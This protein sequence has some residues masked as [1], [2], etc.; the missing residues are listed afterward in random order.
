MMIMLIIVG[1]LFGG[2]FLWKAFNA[3]MMKRYMSSMGSPPMTISTITVKSMPWQSHVKAVGTLRAIIGVNVTTQLAGQVEKIYFSPGA[4]VK[5]NDILVQLNA[6][7]E[8]ALLQ[9]LQ[10]QVQLAKITYERDK[11][12]YAFKAVSKQT[13]DIDEWNLKNKIALTAEQAATVAKKTLR[14][15][16]SGRLGISKVNPGQYL[17]VGDTVTTLQTLDPIFMDFYVPQQELSKL[18]LGQSVVVKA[19]AY[20]KQKYTGTI[21]TIEPAVDVN[22]RNVQVEATIN[23]SKLELLPG[24]FASVEVTTGAPKSYLTLPQSAITFNPYGDIVFIVKKSDKKSDDKEPRDIATQVFITTGETRG[25]QIQVLSGLK[26][27]DVVASSGELKLKNGTPVII[28]NSVQPSNN[29][30]PQVVEK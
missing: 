26:E 12:Q 27:G 29:P 24:M 22:N 19:D 25:D 1:I 10:A 11:N 9:A 20:P 7:A 23:N 17:N 13:V 6:D 28:N 21:T 4:N 14:A 16:F 3:Y 2:V 18:K 8:V 30:D 5:Q 15:P